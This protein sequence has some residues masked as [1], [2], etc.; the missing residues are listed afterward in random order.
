MESGQPARDYALL[1]GRIIIRGDFGHVKVAP[2]LPYRR[3]DKLKMATARAGGRGSWCWFEIVSDH[4]L[5]VM[6]N[7]GWIR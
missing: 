5:L 3:I 6:S 2:T 1:G 7:I 4:P